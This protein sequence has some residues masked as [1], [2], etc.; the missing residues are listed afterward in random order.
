MAES[1]SAFAAVR[2]YLVKHDISH[3]E[4]NGILS[5]NST[6]VRLIAVGDGVTPRTASLFAFRTKWNCISIDPQMRNGAWKEVQNLHTI[7]SRVQDV[8][9]NIKNDEHV[10]IIMWHCH[11]SIVAALSCIHFDQ[12]DK[13]TLRQRVALISC[14]CCNF[15]AEQRV[16]TDSSPPDLQY[17]DV[18]VPG[19]MR[20]VRVWRFEK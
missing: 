18:G 10:V 8:I 6:K 3:E 14:S 7:S 4:Q 11:T 9:V 17:E 19:L 15:D 20:T 2:Q 16:L 1:M 12:S 13:R 5:F